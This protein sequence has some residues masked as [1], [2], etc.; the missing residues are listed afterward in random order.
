MA[1]LFLDSVTGSEKLISVGSFWE[2]KMSKL[3]IAASVGAVLIVAIAPALAGSRGQAS[4][5]VPVCRQ[6]VAA[7][8]LADKSARQAEFRKCMADVA[9]YT[10]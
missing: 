7:K 5:N 10:K 9:A 1:A 4:V 2:G 8:H 3:V 6:A